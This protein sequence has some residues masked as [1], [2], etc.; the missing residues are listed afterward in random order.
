MALSETGNE[1]AAAGADGYTRVAGLT[2]LSER[3][4]MVVKTG[5]KQIALFHGPR[6]VFACNNRCPHEGYPLIEGTI[7]ND[8]VLTCNW[9]AWR[10]DLGSGDNLTGGD[11]LRTYPVRI[12]GD[13]ILLDLSD[14]PAAE[15]IASA[16][17][18]LRDAFDDHEYDRL[19]REVV[20]LQQADGD[21]MD[22]LRA[23][24]RWSHDRF[25]F[26]TT[27][28]YA[29]APDWLAVRDGHAHDDATRLAPV[30]EAIGH[31]AWDSLREPVY[32]Y[33]DKVEPYDEAA[34]LAAIEDEDEPTAI[35]RLRGALADGLDFA[36]LE[37]P[38]TQAAL[39]HYQGFGHAAIYVLKTGQL[40]D[41]LGSD[42]TEPMLLALVRYLA[43]TRRED[44]IPEF[45]KYAEA[46]DAWDGKGDAR[47]A[48]DDF[49]G[50]SVNRALA[51][52][53]EGSG[54]VEM[55][56]H[57]LLGAGA[58][59]FLHFDTGMQASLDAPVSQNID[60]LDFTH[61]ITFANAVR[62]QCTKFPEFWPQG[63]LQMACFAGRNAGFL[64][65]DI[66]AADWAVIDA[67]AFLQAGIDRLFD[68]GE[69]EYIVSCHYVKLLTAVQDEIEAAPAAPW[70]RTL[71]AALNR[72]MHSSI[73]R[74]HVTR[75]ARQALDFVALEG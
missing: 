14:P 19:A 29:A 5:A 53:L 69:F 18:N 21:A 7:A 8:C 72:F 62:H 1:T 52:A 33:A 57:A 71:L 27:H 38:L 56:Y 22:A 46:R 61:A 67:R 28:A 73:K 16:M 50:L 23:A 45:R 49:A 40:I 11:R 36:A 3:G 44:L 68:H 66:D 74:K 55:L 12:D 26:G 42:V 54:D 31:M 59:N 48:A 4:R 63:L 60:W 64:D 30:V 17:T 51:H 13:D 6:G 75:T 32:A 25:E 20:R 35:A 37:R 15:R 65:R 39:A 41:R 9:H 70:T 2:E 58:W 10:F 43:S 47:L 34:F 24:V